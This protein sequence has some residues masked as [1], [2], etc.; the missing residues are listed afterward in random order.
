MYWSVN[1]STRFMNAYGI[2]LRRGGLAQMIMLRGVWV[3]RG[4]AIFPENAFMKSSD[5]RSVDRPILRT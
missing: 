2:G 1:A 4:P 3:L 5:Y